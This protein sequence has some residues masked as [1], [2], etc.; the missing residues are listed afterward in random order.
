[1]AACR[2]PRPIMTRLSRWRAPTPTG[3]NL[4][5]LPDG[6]TLGSTGGVVGGAQVGY[7]FQFNQFVLGVET[8]FQGTSISGNGGNAG[9]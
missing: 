2:A 5:F 9:L 4:F 7:N 8:D 3:P 6:N 1:M